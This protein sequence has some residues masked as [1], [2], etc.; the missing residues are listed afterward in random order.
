MHKEADALVTTPLHGIIAEFDDPDVLIAAAHR[1]REA[2]YKRLDAYTP[3]PVH[4]L[5]EAIGFDDWRIPWFVFLGGL[6]GCLLGFGGLYYSNVVDYPWNVG[7]R[8]L[9]SWPAFIP[10]TFECTVLFSGLTA[11]LTQFLLN[12]LPKPHDSIFN[13]K[14]FDRASQDR[15]FLSV[16]AGDPRFDTEETAAFLRR[17]NGVLDVSEVEK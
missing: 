17:L 1:T 2:G 9:N 11:F 16:E 13:A 15:F 14:N 3:F 6:T 5:A 12:G 8:P 10:I 7:G 4:G